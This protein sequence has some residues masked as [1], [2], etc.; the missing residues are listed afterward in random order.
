MTFS[1]V[2]G[3]ISMLDAGYKSCPSLV[4]G[5]SSEGIISISSSLALGSSGIKAQQR[6]FGPA[7][8]PCFGGSNGALHLECHRYFCHTLGMFFMSFLHRCLPGPQF[9]DFPTSYKFLGG[10]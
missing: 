8:N 7:P 10:K 3:Q 1:Q 9:W 6:F 4:Q 5:T 2:A